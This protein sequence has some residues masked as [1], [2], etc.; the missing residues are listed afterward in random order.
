MKLALDLGQRGVGNTGPHRPSVGCVII[1]EGRLVGRGWTRTG[2]H[3]EFL[4]L[5][6]AGTDSFG[7][8]AYVSLE[9]CSHHGRTPPCAELLAAAGITEVVSAIEDPNPEV[10]GAGHRH[11]ESA[12]VK[13]RTG[14][15][16]DRALHDHRGFFLS[17][18]DNRPLVT[19]KL[20]QTL[21]G[22]LADAT[23]ASKW[24]TGPAARRRVHLMRAKHDAVLVGRGTVAA[25]DPMLT[26]RE[27]GISR[28]PARI[29]LDSKLKSHPTCK[30]GQS[31]AEAPVWIC[32]THLAPESSADAW[33]KAGAALISC[34]NSPDGIDLRDAFEK[35]SKWGIVRVLCEGGAYLAAS[36]LKA[37]LVDDL[38][39]FSA[40][41]SLGAD[42]T[43]AIAEMNALAIT[44]ATRF[45]LDR[46]EV[47]GRDLLHVW[48]RIR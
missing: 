44:D 32:H 23:G 4:A 28:S 14:C 45:R 8:T 40:G 16:R 36:L 25:D 22:R 12:G 42:A 41:F 26:P 33:L 3:A 38:V 18:L 17:I 29:F 2:A 1:R 11:L 9:P 31:I 47:I 37:D 15:M 21:D 6:M 39:L 13:V 46:S 34:K 48:T 35:I 10:S 20:A 19:L 27:L 43:P 7:A 5:E 24:M 30:L